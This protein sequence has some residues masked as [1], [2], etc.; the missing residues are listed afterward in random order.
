MEAVADIDLQLELLHDD[1]PAEP[2]PRHD[3]FLR[4]NCL[5]AQCES[6]PDS[7]DRLS[8][9][10]HIELKGSKTL[11]LNGP[12]TADRSCAS[13]VLA[14]TFGFFGI[15]S[16]KTP[17]AM[18]QFVPPIGT[19]FYFK[20]YQS[21][22]LR[23]RLQRQDGV[24][25]H[26]PNTIQL[27]AFRGSV[28]YYGQLKECR[29]CGSL[30][31]LVADC[32]RNICRICKATDHT[33]ANC[34][35]PVK[36]NL[37]SS[38][39]HR[40]KDCPHAYSNRVK[41]SPFEILEAREEERATDE[42]ELSQASC[43]GTNQE[44]IIKVSQQQIQEPIQ[45]QEKETS[46]GESIIDWSADT[47][48]DLIDTTYIPLPMAHATVQKA[49]PLP[50]H[51]PGTR[52][53]RIP[54]TL[55]EAE[56]TLEAIMANITTPPPQGK[57][58][59]REDTPDTAQASVP[60]VP[61]I[62]ITQIKDA[63]DS[64]SRKRLQESPQSDT[65]RAKN[66][67][68]PGYTWSNGKTHSRIDFLLTS[69]GLQVIN[70]SVKPVFF[71]DH[72]K[73]DCLFDFKEKVIRGRGSWKMN[74]SLLENPSIVR[75][76]K[77]K[78]YMWSS[79]EFLFDSVGDWWEE[80]K[81]RT[82]SFF[83]EEG[84]KE[85]KKKRYKFK[86][87]QAKL[88]R[89]YTM[90]YA[91][92]DV[93]EDIARLKRDMSHLTTEASRGLLTRSRVH[94]MENNEKCTRY[95]FRKLARPRNVMDAI[96]DKNGKEQTDINDILASAKINRSKSE[97]LYLNWKE[98]KVDLGLVERKERVKMLG[99]EIGRGMENVN[100]DSRLPAIKGKLLRA[101]DRALT[102]T[103]KILVIKVEILASLTHLA[104]T[105]PAKSPSEHPHAETRP[106]LYGRAVTLFKKAV[107]NKSSGLQVIN[108]SVKPV[109][110]SDHA[111]IDCLFDFKEKV[112]RG[113][114]SWKMNT[115]LLENPSIVRRFKE[116]IYMWS[117]LEFLFDSV[118]DWWEEF[119]VR[120]KSFFI[121]EGK[122]EAKKKRYKFK[123]QQ[124]KLQRL[125]TMAYAGLDV[126][127]DIARLKRDMS[128][129]TTEAS[130]GLLTRS[131]VHH[132]ENNEKC[133]RYFFRKL[134]RPRNVMDAIKDKN[135]KEQTDI[136]DILASVYSFYS[137]LYKSEDLDKAALAN[138]LSK[139]ISGTGKRAPLNIPHAETRPPL[140]GRAVTLFK[141]A[142]LNK[143]SVDF[144]NRRRD[145]LVP[146]SSQSVSFLWPLNISVPCSGPHSACHAP[147][148][149][150]VPFVTFS[151]FGIESNRVPLLMCC[152]F[153]PAGS[154]IEFHIWP[155]SLRVNPKPPCCMAV[156]PWLLFR[157]GPQVAPGH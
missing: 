157:P 85:A 52:K 88:Q 128:H 101:E 77:E 36:C 19:Y 145:F 99:I 102:F 138:L 14:L 84:K 154:V 132:M 113:R 4:N 103:G 54:G 130:R 29:K 11:G 90:A 67:N 55:Q 7:W 57:Q 21:L 72:A 127:E 53:E 70:A 58:V 45:D 31:H 114:G 107:L 24:L 62:A 49:D 6:Q 95:F 38:E 3:L 23:V 108:A 20:P 33:S 140:Y 32:S 22:R 43:S 150:R 15:E 105:L 50:N 148:P 51:H 25:R 123:I 5:E 65:Y 10:E 106:P 109:F 124:A 8:V 104:A 82:K 48:D 37:C 137:D 112:I 56:N 111:K 126:A 75:R 122:K 27:G 18:L 80:F 151:S 98:D 152:S 135:G 41:H 155:G 63:R 60:L 136:N 118:G 83:I 146:M 133:T 59:L 39:N 116:K 17:A 93:A 12:K 44:P 30:D 76:F 125:Y 100:W 13:M 139:F 16:K 81:V 134:A 74:T 143:S 73:I 89:L 34:P 71:S 117:S 129:L 87:Q 64:P 46:E 61:S 131:R 115:S 26:I 149:R 91:G 66:A 35:T 156:V 47:V 78:I 110:F 147:E 42:P 144:V 1:F 141:K 2:R 153:C 69:K 97:I 119:K 94:H 142:V 9:N 96:K 120:T 28:F 68:L 92:L 79:L 40:F 121:E 86:I